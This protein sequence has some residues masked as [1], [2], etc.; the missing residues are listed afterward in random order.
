MPTGAPPRQTPTMWLGL[1]PARKIFM[2]SAMESASNWSA[3]MNV[4]GMASA[5]TGLLL[6]TL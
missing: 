3:E 2:P 1:K 6:R 5:V 4:L